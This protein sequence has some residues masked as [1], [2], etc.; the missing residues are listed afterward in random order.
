MKTPE[1][2]NR[3]SNSPTAPGGRLPTAPRSVSRG[4]TSA[5]RRSVFLKLAGLAVLTAFLAIGC[6]H[7][8]GIFASLE[9]EIPVD[10]DR[11][12]PTTDG[13]RAMLAVDTDDNGGYFYAAFTSL[14]VRE[15]SEGLAV[16]ADSPDNDWS[17]ISKPGGLSAD[18]VLQSIAEHEIN[19]ENRVF[20]VYGGGNSGSL[21][22]RATG[23]D[24]SSGAWSDAI[25][26]NEIASDTSDEGSPEKVSKVFSANGELIVSV[27]IKSNSD[28]S[29]S[30]AVYRPV[31][32]NEP[33]GNWERIMIEEGETDGEV[34]F[35]YDFEYFDANNGNGD[36]Y[37]AT[38]RNILKSDDD[39]SSGG[40]EDEVHSGSGPYRNLLAA[41]IS[42]TDTLFAAAKG[43]IFST[44][45]APAETGDWASAEISGEDDVQFTAIGY[46]P[47][48]DFEGSDPG[49]YLIAGTQDN[50]LYE[51][52]ADT[53]G[54]YN[55]REEGAE[56]TLLGRKG[57]FLT[58]RLSGRGIQAIFV[59]NDAGTWRSEGPH[60]FVGAA[61]AGLWRGEV[62]EDDDLAGKFL[63]RRE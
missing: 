61:T 16:D 35:V 36:Y 52:E 14:Y 10:E 47:G 33:D 13:M 4:R 5:G 30:Y 57:N 25:S 9:E 60:V 39:L 7:P 41:D 42:G 8:V 20:A 26:V 1:Q 49:A 2:N 28:K 54:G 29:D 59:D 23:D 21:Y 34:G 32:A 43:V 48:S 58:T 63:W 17:R 44:D 38:F 53:T 40:F 51:A 55:F 31:D 50:G 12:V 22:H 6:R 45:S 27:R 37:L 15:R 11:G 18:D 46:Y 56:R 3:T 19:G 24:T 62:D